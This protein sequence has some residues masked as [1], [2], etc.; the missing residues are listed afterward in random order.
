MF[1]VQNDSLVPVV[2]LIN[3]FLPVV[4]L[5]TNVQFSKTGAIF[6]PMIEIGHEPA[7][8]AVPITTFAMTTLRNVIVS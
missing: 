6:L 7:V 4:L 1:W 5:L 2:Q 8:D 3:G